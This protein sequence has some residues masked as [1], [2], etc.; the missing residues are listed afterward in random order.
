MKLKEKQDIFNHW[1]D[2]A[3]TN[4]TFK[5]LKKNNFVR[6]ILKFQISI[7]LLSLI[8]ILNPYRIVFNVYEIFHGI[9]PLDY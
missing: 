7:E 1:I 6:L 4:T 2:L 8:Y 5:E 9:V 3:L